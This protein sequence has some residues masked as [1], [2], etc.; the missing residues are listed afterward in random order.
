M[1]TTLAL[2]GLVMVQGIWMAVRAWV[3]ADHERRLSAVE[4]AVGVKAAEKRIVA[5]REAFERARRRMADPL[6]QAAPELRDTLPAE[7]PPPE[8]ARVV[9]VT[10]ERTRRPGEYAIVGSRGLPVM[11]SD[12][13]AMGT[14]AWRSPGKAATG[15]AMKGQVG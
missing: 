8:V 9:E 14:K 10:V 6:A 5:D 3:A 4:E 2:I 15:E 12:D 1:E 13:R 7:P 11:H